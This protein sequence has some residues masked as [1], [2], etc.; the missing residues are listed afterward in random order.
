MKDVRKTIGLCFF[1]LFGG[2]SWSP[3]KPSWG[4][5]FR[6]LE[7]ILGRRAAMGLFGAILGRLGGMLG[8]V[9]GLCGPPEAILGRYEAILGVLEPFWAVLEACWA[10][11]AAW[12]A[13]LGRF[14]AFGEPQGGSMAA[15]GP[16][17]VGV[18]Q[19]SLCDRR[20]VGA[21]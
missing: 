10:M 15:Q 20:E 2:S 11:L 12:T 13:L 6:P 1:V 9:G 5:S 7:A 21:F 16:P 14:G 8:H 19:S 4:V 3:L 18:M 17:G